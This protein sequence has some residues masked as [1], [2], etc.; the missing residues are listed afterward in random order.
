M[1]ARARSRARAR[2]SS[3][4]FL[5]LH[6]ESIA[7]PVPDRKGLDFRSPRLLIAPPTLAA[8]A[9]PLRQVAQR[10]DDLALGNVEGFRIAV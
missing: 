3:L 4:K 10:I 8:T 2:E 6:K 9:M 1:T 5:Y 7:Q